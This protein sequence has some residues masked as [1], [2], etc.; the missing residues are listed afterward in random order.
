[1]SENLDL[2]RSIYADWERGDFASVEWADPD[3]VYVRPDGPDPGSWTG[4]VEMAEGIRAR[5]SAWEDF[6]TG[7]V[8]YRELDDGRVL[9]FIHQ[10]GRGKASGLKLGQMGSKGA[11]LFHV[12]GGKVT[13]LI[14][15]MG[16]ENALA[17]LG[18]QE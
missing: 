10:S 3:I 18:L 4:L 5:L 13:R 7:A 9:V 17:D 6:R 11:V 8:E 2:V 15:Y 1:M 14:S 16:R 12:S